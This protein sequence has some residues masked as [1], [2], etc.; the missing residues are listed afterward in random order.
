MGRWLSIVLG[1][2]RSAV[3]THRALALENLALRLQLAV[4]KARHSRPRLTEMDRIFWILLAR[5]W[6]NRRHSLQ[7][8]RPETVV[9]WH[10]DGFRRYW[11]WKSRRRAGRPAISTEVRD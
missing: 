1:T 6:T 11:A 5:L 10:R 4:L 3:R 7:L 8:V 9:R 2:R